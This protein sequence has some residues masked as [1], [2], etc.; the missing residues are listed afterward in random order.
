MTRLLIDSS[1]DISSGF[2]AKNLENLRRKKTT[3]NFFINLLIS[4]SL[5]CFTS[6]V[7]SLRSHCLV[8]FRLGFVALFLSLSLPPAILYSF[9]IFSK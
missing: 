5:R 4:S 9:N 3:S 2:Y 7:L 1:H 8:G 6:S